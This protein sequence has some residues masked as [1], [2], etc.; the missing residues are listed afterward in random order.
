MSKGLTGKPIIIFCAGVFGGRALEHFGSDRVHCFADNF[1]HG[2]EFRGKPVISFEKLVEIASD[3]DVV[4]AVNSSVERNILIQLT[5]AGIKAKVFQEHIEDIYNYES[6]PEI[7]KFH[8][9]HKGKRCFLI[10]N[11]PSLRSEDLDKL[12]TNK[13]ITF[14]CNTIYKIFS[15]TNWRPNY[16]VATHIESPYTESLA[17]TEV[18]VKFIAK[19]EFVAQRSAKHGIENTEKKLKDI[20]KSGKGHYCYCNFVY[21]RDPKNYYFSNDSSRVIPVSGTVMIG[22]M[23]LAAYMGFEKIYL[24]GVDGQA[25]LDGKNYENKKLHFHEDSAVEKKRQL[26]IVT[27]RACE[28]PFERIAAYYLTVEAYSRSHGFCVYNATRESIVE[29]FERVDFD[30]LFL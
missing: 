25:Y 23:Q 28:K 17:A 8:N 21:I 7:A 18:E 29:A 26:E 12:Y 13:D 6:N 3:Y 19:P 15:Q 1:M 20:L 24:L 4:V 10:G 27:A 14:G 2:H 11:G 5:N 16:Y 22:M 9:I 30:S